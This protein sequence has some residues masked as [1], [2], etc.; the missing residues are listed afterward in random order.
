[1]PPSTTTPAPA[2][3]VEVTAND[4]TSQADYERENSEGSK[5]AADTWRYTS[6]SPDG[7]TKAV[8]NLFS[9]AIASTFFKSASISNSPH[10]LPSNKKNLAEQQKGFSCL[11]HRWVIAYLF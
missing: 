2:E 3:L 8:A 1:M 10:F 9:K 7:L 6:I 5:A 11:A 4:L